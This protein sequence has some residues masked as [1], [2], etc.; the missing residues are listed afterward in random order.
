MRAENMPTETQRPGAKKVGLA[1][2][3]FAFSLYLCV[4]VA[5]IFVCPNLGG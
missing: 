1:K 2:I 3:F 5:G 4:S